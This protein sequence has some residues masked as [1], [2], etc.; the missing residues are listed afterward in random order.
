MAGK[1]NT[2]NFGLALGITF[3]IGALFLGLTSWLFSYG[4]AWVELIG[5]VYICYTATLLGSLIGT[6]YAFVDAFIGGL[7]I[8]WFYN[9]LQGR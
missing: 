1:L 4:N 8:A 2:V 5:G 9:K 7:L 3:G 6:I